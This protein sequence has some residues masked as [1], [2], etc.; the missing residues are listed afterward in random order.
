MLP[1][2]SF[3]KTDE[4]I[5]FKLTSQT[6][7]V[8]ELI[9]EN[10]GKRHREKLFSLSCRQCFLEVSYLFLKISDVRHWHGR[11]IHPT[12]ILCML[13]LDNSKLNIDALY[14]RIC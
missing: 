10:D 6:A 12:A 2:A 7:I 11:N 14:N 8:A 13:R 4:H 9:V 3:Y 1:G 5:R